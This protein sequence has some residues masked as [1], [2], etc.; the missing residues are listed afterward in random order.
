MKRNIDWDKVNELVE[1]FEKLTI[2]EMFYCKAI[3]WDIVYE[4]KYN[5][6]NRGKKK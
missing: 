3:L 6:L 2:D 5:P 1:M 4:R